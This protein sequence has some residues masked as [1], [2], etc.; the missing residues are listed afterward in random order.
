[1]GRRSLRKVDPA[2]DLSRHLKTLDDVPSPWSALALF[3]REAPLE[4]ELPRS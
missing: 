2:L 1:M 3:G 4:V